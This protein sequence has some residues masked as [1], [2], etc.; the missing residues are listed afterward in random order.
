VL[1]RPPSSWPWRAAAISWAVTALAWGVS[2]VLTTVLYGFDLGRA[3]DHLVPTA[4]SCVAGGLLGLASRLYDCTWLRPDGIVVRRLLHGERFVPW[5]EVADIS[6]RTS[7]G[8]RSV[9]V[10]GLFGSVT[11]AAPSTSPLQ[12]NRD[13]DTEVATIMVWWRHGRSWA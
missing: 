11:L 5:S 2:Q 10:W 3:L 4:A 7:F 12:R 9:Q 1:L 8:W 6:V 13:F